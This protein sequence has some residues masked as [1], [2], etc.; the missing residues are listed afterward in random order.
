MVR[1]NR[2]NEVSVDLPATNDA[3]LIFIGRTRT[4]WI[5]RLQCPR[6]GGADR[7]TTGGTG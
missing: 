1:L 7:R 2:Q 4:S 3:G 6:Q 5:D